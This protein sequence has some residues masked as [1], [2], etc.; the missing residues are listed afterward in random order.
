[1]KRYLLSLV[2]VVPLAAVFPA[3]SAETCNAIHEN[4]GVVGDFAIAVSRTVADRAAPY[5]GAVV[6][7]ADWP[8]YGEPSSTPEAI[9]S[10]GACSA[11]NGDDAC[12]VCL[13][14][15]CCAPI[16]DCYEDDACRCQLD[17][18]APESETSCSDCGPSDAFEAALSCTQ[19]NCAEQCPG[20]K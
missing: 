11:A 10:G 14:A 2:L 20:A 15:S 19:E 5:G 16:A 18:R 12:I 7:G 17:C 6:C 13:K 4:L 3:C 9:K 8:G 1:M